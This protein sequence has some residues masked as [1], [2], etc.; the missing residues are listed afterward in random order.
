MKLGL[1][2]IDARIAEVVAVAAARG[3]KFAAPAGRWWW[4]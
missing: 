1:L 2:G 3:D 4:D